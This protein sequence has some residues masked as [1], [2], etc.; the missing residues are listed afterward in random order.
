VSTIQ[1]SGVF[2]AVTA[3]STKPL[4]S[5]P[6]PVCALNAY[7]WLLQRMAPSMR[8]LFHR[9][10]AP[11]WG[12]RA[13]NVRMVDPILCTNTGLPPAVSTPTWLSAGSVPSR[14]AKPVGRLDEDE[15]VGDEDGDDDDGADD[16]AG[17]G[18][19]V[20]GAGAAITA[21]VVTARIRPLLTLIFTPGS[22][23]LAGPD[24]T[25]PVSASNVESW[26]LQVMRFLVTRLST[27]HPW[28]V[29]TAEYALNF[30]F[31]GWVS[32]TGLPLSWTRRP[33]PTGIED[34][35]PK[36]CAG[37]GTAAAADAN[38]TSAAAVA[39]AP[40]KTSRR[41]MHEEHVSSATS[42]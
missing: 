35:G 3:R 7:P 6:T 12:H 14:R 8:V 36:S 30:P 33:P 34:A 19:W 25:R 4:L 2:T 1:P 21:V 22:A 20:V 39:T 31:R 26:H 38:G 15:A 29:H 28:C 27:T 23:R 13:E 40:P 17:G 10:V 24:R 16:G 18:G 37:I 11:A 42:R 5:V 41:E 32:I 9:F